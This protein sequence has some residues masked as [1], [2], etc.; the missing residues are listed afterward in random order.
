MFKQTL[1]GIV[2]I[3]LLA[4]IVG[5]AAAQTGSVLVTA[6][7]PEGQHVMLTEHEWSW[8]DDG[9]VKA[10][11]NDIELFQWDSRG[12]FRLD[13]SEAEPVFTVGYRLFTMHIDTDHPSLP[14]GLTDLAIAAGWRVG[15]FADDWELGI[16]GGAGA[17]TNN[18]FGDG[19][20]Y[21]G[22]ASLNIRHTIDQSSEL[23]FGA[24][25]DG[26]RS[27]MPDVPLPYVMYSRY[28]DENLS[29]HI[30][31]PVSSIRYQ[32]LEQLTL[33][34]RYFVPMSFVGSIRWALIEDRLSLFG[35]YDRR[36]NAFHLEDQIDTRRLF[37]RIQRAKLGLAYTA[38]EC[39]DIEGGIGYAFEQ[40]FDSGFDLRNTDTV[41][42]PSDE[43]FLF[44]ALEASF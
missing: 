32:P 2:P 24:N 26:N 39:L 42:E 28:V 37:Y 16:V 35:S 12:R 21:Y 36:V 38:G 9:H 8:I 14:G 1:L 15:E 10:D 7:W 23:N 40:S 11:D 25:Y 22:L 3:V 41:A 17:A 34:A 29:Y 31:A 43:V 27:F 33:E 6:P 13:P 20:A 5:S 19:D 18:H 4:C 44:L 30:G